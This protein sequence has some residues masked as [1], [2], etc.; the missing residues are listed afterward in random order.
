M[1]AS[2]SPCAALSART[3]Q[4]DAIE[5]QRVAGEHV[6]QQDALE[7]LGEIERDLHRDLRLL[8]ADE[9]QRQEQ[10]GEQ[11]ADRIEPAEE[12][13]DDRGEAVARR[14]AGLQ[15]ADRAPRPR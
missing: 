11:D 3:D 9:G 12:G 15:M 1:M 13:D 10:A 14:D 8:A 2:S 5:D 4:A 7:D 6:E